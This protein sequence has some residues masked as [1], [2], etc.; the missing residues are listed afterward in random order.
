[1]ATAVE[2]DGYGQVR[3]GQI[4]EGRW[5]RLSATFGSGAEPTAER[6]DLM[7]DAMQSNAMQR[8]AVC[9]A[10]CWV[11]ERRRSDALESWSLGVAAGRPPLFFLS[12]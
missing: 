8:C 10:A 12:L 11:P 5:H 7:R 6:S 4:D 9:S 2:C 3:L 1:M